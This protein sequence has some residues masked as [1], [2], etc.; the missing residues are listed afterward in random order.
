MKERK[1]IWAPLYVVSNDTWV[2]GGGDLRSL[3]KGHPE[4]QDKLEGVVEG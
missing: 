2:C 3:G 1:M 4:D